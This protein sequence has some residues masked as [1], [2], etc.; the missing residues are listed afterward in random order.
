MITFSIK[1]LNKTDLYSGQ[2]RFKHLA[3][4]AK[5]LLLTPHSNSYCESIFSAIRNICTEVRQ[6]ILLKV[7]HLLV[8]TRKQHI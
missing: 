4:F 1:Y 2:P 5:F 8:Y 3:K 6:M 7:M